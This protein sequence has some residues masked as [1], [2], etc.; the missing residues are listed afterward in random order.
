MRRLR[1]SGSQ[2][3]RVASGCGEQARQHV[4]HEP[5]RRA[6][7]EQLGRAD[8]QVKAA[9]AGLGGVVRASG[10]SATAYVST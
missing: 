2:T 6:A 1:T 10:S 3:T 8:E 5:P 9:V 7:A 4:A